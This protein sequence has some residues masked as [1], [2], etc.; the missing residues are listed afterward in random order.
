MHVESN[1]TKD[2]RNP[3]RFPQVSRVAEVRR[4]ADI[5]PSEKVFVQDRRIHTRN[6][7][8][9]YIG[10]NLD[11]IH[12]DDVPTV[13][14]GGSGGGF[15]AMIAYMGY[16]EE[17]KRAGLWDLLTFVSGVSGSCWAIASYYTFGEASMTKVIE[18]CKKRLSPYHPL[19][20]DAVRT[21]LKSKPHETLGPI[22]AKRHSGLH[23][24]A[25]DLYSVFT[26]G[27]LFLVGRPVVKTWYAC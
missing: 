24:V 1:I 4:G 10:L 23:S 5:S 12:P 18:H 15:R 27:Y 2:L 13:A 3:Q 25:M 9:R 21:L 20:P 19:S 16:S 26:T 11:Q 8:A 22:V 14:F 6:H 17:L 7:F